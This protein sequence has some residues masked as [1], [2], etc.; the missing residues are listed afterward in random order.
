MCSS[1]TSSFVKPTIYSKFNQIFYNIMYSNLPDNTWDG[2]PRAPWNQE[3]DDRDD[4]FGDEATEIIENEIAESDNEFVCWL[5]DSEYLPPEAADVSAETLEEMIDNIRENEQI[6][7]EYLNYRWE[8]VIDGIIET[9][10]NSIPD[11]DDRDDD[12]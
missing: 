1:T 10:Y 3:D 5:I 11:Y 2:D 8:D 7:E 12:Y 9:R 4:V 6:C